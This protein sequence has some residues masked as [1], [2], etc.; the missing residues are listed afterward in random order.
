MHARIVTGQV[1]LDKIDQATSTFEQQIL[2]SLRQ[3]RGFQRTTLYADRGSGKFIA[4]SEYTS[5]E[6]L[7][8]SEAGF[9]QRTGMMA[10]L[11]TGR[12][13]AETY[14]VVAQG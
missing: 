5:G 13:S 2:P 10:G 12:P 1:P 4:V 3:E 11:L 7:A 14:E 9:Q 8:A 6:D